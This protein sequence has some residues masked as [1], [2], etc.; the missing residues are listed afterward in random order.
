MSDRILILD[1]GS[2]VT[3][4]I[5][6]RLR[7]AGVYCEIFPFNVETQRI[8]DFAPRGIVLSGGP[9]SVTAADTPRAPDLVF[10]LGVPL[11]G[12]CYGQQALCAQLGG[13]VENADHHEFGR[14][15]LRITEDCPLFEGI[16]REGE[17]HQVWMSHG[18]RVIRLPE[19]FRVVATS[20]GAPF[21]AA[22]DDAR[23]YYGLMFHPEVVHTPDGGRLLERFA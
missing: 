2:Q 8:R 4:L 7:E 21:A 1:F 17:D 14:A 3:Q 5:A 11:L 15:L 20:E 6:R 9:A 23:R 16:W 12:I 18:D 19:G 10:E 22:V 13:E